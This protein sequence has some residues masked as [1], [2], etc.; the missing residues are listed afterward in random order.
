MLLW[1]ARWLVSRRSISEMLNWIEEAAPVHPPASGMESQEVSDLVAAATRLAM[2]AGS[3]L[4]QALVTCRLLRQQG[5]RASLVIGTRTGTP[6][7]GS[8]PVAAHAWVRIASPE[9][10]GVWREFHRGD[11]EELVELS[12]TA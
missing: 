6:S 3:C 12:K 2:P 4:P 10:S 8:G 7:A 11:H 9:R 5:H 1:R